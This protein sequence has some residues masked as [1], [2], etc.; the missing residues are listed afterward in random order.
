MKA[1]A[2][3]MS[4]N[5]ISTTGYKNLAQSSASV[6]NDFNIQQFSAVTDKSVNKFLGKK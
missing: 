1:Y 4:D 3:V 5:K 6:G 2:I